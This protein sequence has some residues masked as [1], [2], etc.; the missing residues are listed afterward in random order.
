MIIW[1]GTTLTLTGALGTGARYDPASDAWHQTNP[2]DAP[3][4]R[5]THTA[6]WTG[7]EMIVWGGFQNTAG[8]LDTGGRYSPPDRDADGDGISLCDGDCDDGDDRVYPGAPQA[9]GD[10]LNNDCL[11]PVWPALA[12]TIEADDDGDGP[13]E[14]VGDCDDAEAGV[15]PEAADLPGDAIDDD[16]DGTPACDP[17][18]GWKARGNFAACVVRACSQLEGAGLVTRQEC[19]AILRQAMSP[20]R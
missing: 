13:S 19:A 6:I 15:H 10:D 12:G 9:C 11:D 2:V 8:S 7:S 4:P 3:S 1:G 18:S 16:C 17:A 5:H 14:C 20:L